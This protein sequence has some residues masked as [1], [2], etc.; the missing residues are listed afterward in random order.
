MQGTIITIE[1]AEGYIR[2]WGLFSRRVRNDR[3]ELIRLEIHG[4]LLGAPSVGIVGN[5]CCLRAL[6]AA[7]G[8]R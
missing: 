8:M 2:R 5:Q 4:Q 3:G 6:K 1:Q 7:C